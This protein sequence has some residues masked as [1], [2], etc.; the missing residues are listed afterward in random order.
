MWLL[1]GEDVIIPS[2]KENEEL[3]SKKVS[4]NSDVKGSDL[5]ILQKQTKP[6][7]SKPHKNSRMY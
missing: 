1:E 5:M 7:Q 6:Q 3:S 2:H 4:A